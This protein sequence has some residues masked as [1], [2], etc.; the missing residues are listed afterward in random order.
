MKSRYAVQVITLESSQSDL[1]FSQ[2]IRAAAHGRRLGTKVLP[3]HKSRVEAGERSKRGVS[4]FRIHQGELPCI[5][6]DACPEKV[7]TEWSKT[8]R[9]RN[10]SNTVTCASWT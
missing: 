5:L 1:Q 9:T 4:D 6:E 3:E 8:V 7:G 2:E 10:I